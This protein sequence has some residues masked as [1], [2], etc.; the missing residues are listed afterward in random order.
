MATTATAEG[1]RARS[2][3]LVAMTL[4]NSMILVDQTAVPIAIPRVVDG[5]DASLSAGQWVLVANALPLAGLMVFGGRIGDLLG[6]RRVFLIGAVGF[7]VSSALAGAAQSMPWLLTMRAT[8]GVGAALMMP[9]TM[10]IVSVSYSEEDRGR[11]LGIMAGASAFF[12]AVGPIVGGMLT[13]Y[14]DWRAV[15]LVN[16]PLAVIVVLL[17][18]GNTP[19]IRPT[20]AGSRGIDVPGLVAFTL[21]IGSLTL[22]LG[23][24]Q[25]WGWNSPLTLAALVVGVGGLVAFV[26]IERRPDPLMDLSLFRHANFAAA[27]ISQFIAGMVELGSAFLLPYF[28]LLVIGLSPAAAGLAL[29]P[30]TVPIIVVAP[31]AGRWFDRV[32]GRVPLTVG[33]VVLAASSFALAI[34]FAE[35]GLVA[36]VPG[37]VLQGIALGIVLTVND[38][39]GINS[40]PEKVRGQ[41]SGVV[42]TS[43]QLGGAI[44]IAVFAMLFHAFY[45]RRLIDLVEGRGFSITTDEWER[46]RDFVMQAEQEGLSQVEPPRFIEL[47]LTEFKQAHVEAY[48]FV[49]I[50]IGV[51]ALLGA[52]VCFRMVRRDDRLLRTRVFSRRSRW[53]WA[54]TG[55]GP[56]ITRKPAEDES[57]E[58]S[59][60]DVA[61]AEGESRSPP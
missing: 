55:R 10:A 24:G 4:A 61:N 33:F 37:L 43:E 13:Q 1:R 2:L 25:V 32:G 39:T 14:I 19:A 3:T 59:A 21:G 26:R 46:G 51:L 17:T 52:F 23:Q 15:F 44:G 42:D 9:T 41:A 28:L 20:E 38:P 58:L 34:G 30:A 49:F 18:L 54:S 22:A 47:V 36:L 16:V 57:D 35:E 48:Q 27:N 40:V 50:V 7:T 12:A 8:Q 29:I 56:S 5:L 53:M 60:T 6:L 45:Y 11:A 31:L